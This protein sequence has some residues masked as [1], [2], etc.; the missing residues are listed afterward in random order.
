MIK[1][2]SIIS[3]YVPAVIYIVILFFLTTNVLKRMFG[4]SKYKDV[5]EDAS[6][7]LEHVGIHNKQI[8]EFVSMFLT[9]IL[10][11]F[12]WT[13]FAGFLG[14]GNNSKDHEQELCVSARFC[15]RDS[16]EFDRC[17][18]TFTAAFPSGSCKSQLESDAMNAAKSPR[19]LPPPA[20][21]QPRTGRNQLPPPIN[22]DTTRD[23]R[24]EPSLPSP[25]PKEKTPPFAPQ[26][27]T[28]PAPALSLSLPIL[29]HPE[30]EHSRLDELLAARS[31]WRLH[32]VKADAS[33]LSLLR[34]ASDKDA[35]VF[36]DEQR[37][38]WQEIQAAKDILRASKIGI[39][40]ATLNRLPVYVKDV[41]VGSKITKK[42]AEELE[43]AGFKIIHDEQHAA[44]VFV[45][46]ARKISEHEE[47]QLFYGWTTEATLSAY[48]T[49]T[50][51]RE[52]TLRTITATGSAKGNYNDS[53]SKEGLEME[54]LLN[55]AC[56]AA[57][58][59][60]KSVGIGNHQLQC[61]PNSD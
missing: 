32:G 12:V 22:E 48:V 57:E 25:N 33:A 1:F 41:R 28:L 16:C 9:S 14:F 2:I 20:L 59:F 61:G 11:Y 58:Q 3:E 49:Y 21:E 55:A 13:L 23:V 31:E 44:V 34:S 42:V 60:I 24:P 30:T 10:I 5:L 51:N 26:P 29:P 27:K 54:A 40:A 36:A 50:D 7:L 53:R 4:V 38:A 18:N 43:N 19:C 17:I 47:M 46:S 56:S 45:L 8:I 52:K 35:V 39:S 37:S 15:I 6:R